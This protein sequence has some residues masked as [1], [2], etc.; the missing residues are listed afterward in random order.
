MIRKEEILHDV[1]IK[2]AGDSGDG[3][4]LTGTQFTNNTALL[5]I[6]LSTFP[7]F[8]AEIRAPQGTLPGV[9]GFQ[10]R[11]SSDRVYTPGDACDVLVAMNAAALKTNLTALKKG[12]KIIVNTDGFDSKNLRLANY[13]EG[14]N[15]L[16]NGSLG[17]Y[18]VIKIDVTK[19]TREAL[20]E[21]T[22]GM[23]EKD[24]AKNM[25]VLGFLYWMYGRDMDNTLSFLK[26]KFGKKPDIYDSNMKVLQAGYNFGDTTETFGTIYKV[27]KAKMPSG[28]YRS[29][30]G[31]QALSYG[32]IAASQK[33]GL[34]LFLGSYPITPAS[35]ILHELSRHKNFGIKTFQAEDEIAAITTAIGAAYGGSLGVTAT[36]GPGLAL[37]AEAMGLAVMLE[38]PLVIIDVQ[39]GGPSTGLPTKTEQSDL[40]QAYY[41]R[42]GE[43]PMPVIAASTPADCFDAV[44]EAVRIAV[45]HMTPVILLSDGYIANGAEPWKFPKAEELPPI[46]VKFKTE[47][48]DHEE[49]LQPYLRDEKLA[50]PWALP[51]TPG[52][53]HRIGG[54]EKQNVT[55][56]ISYEPENHQLMVKIRQEKVDKIA[57]Y[58]PEQKIDNGPEKGK[59]LVLGWGSTY[60]AIKS[61]VTELLAQGHAVSHVHLRHVRPFPKNLGAILNNYEK[62]LI[63]EINNGQLI[64][65]IRDVYFIDAK[66][67]NKIMGIPITKTELVEVIRE[68][69][70]G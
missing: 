32:L 16:E 1:V 47:L 33:S 21:F 23:K 29:V 5:G 30:M 4:Q 56:N 17:N 61:A 48:G 50:R 14:E 53:E 13:P 64:K 63:P 27:E 18:E 15:P 19:M 55:G 39:R 52:L 3:M 36:S 38:I 6:D 59:I 54:L 66:G 34:P 65:I 60:G 11:F 31:N 9:S 10:L 20:K 24:R 40:L 45:Q 7:D 49:K 35:D 28:A 22:M 69:L 43:C 46:H 12:G 37:K 70:V 41:G 57:E 58:I 44:Y 68:M 26:E 42:N 25:F 51:G 2:F 62:V 67:Y 8:P